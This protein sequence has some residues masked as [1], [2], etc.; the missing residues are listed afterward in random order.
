M[1]LC[2]CVKH[3]P[4]PLV[5]SSQD[6]VLVDDV[7]SVTG[8]NQSRSIRFIER[9]AEAGDR[10]WWTWSRARP[11]AMGMFVVVTLP[12]AF[13]ERDVMGRHIVTAGMRSA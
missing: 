6:T 13:D 10:R 11:A 7:G 4:L 3:G 9:F 5:I 1:P 12:P 8:A 2:F